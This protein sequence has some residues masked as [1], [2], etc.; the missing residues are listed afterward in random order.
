MFFK[1]SVLKHMLKDAYK[2]SGLTVGHMAESG[3]GEPEGYYAAGSWW[4]M[5]FDKAKMP[6]EVKGALVELCGDLPDTGEVFKAIKDM[7]NQY[8]IEQK[9]IYNLPY[10]FKK[11][12]YR[13][14]V[15]RLLKQQKFDL[16]RFLQDEKE[17]RSVKAVSETCISLIDPSAVD[18]DNGEDMPDGPITIGPSADFMYWGNNT[19]YFMA[20]TRKPILEDEEEMR[21]WDH[22][23]KIKI[24]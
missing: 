17:I 8:E 10:A 4:V 18:Q 19:C 11:C 22:L 13:F 6:K 24:K 20:G 23:T 9:D 21:L 2:S 15:T 16:I 5:W 14:R 1:L 3:T 7:G 12:D